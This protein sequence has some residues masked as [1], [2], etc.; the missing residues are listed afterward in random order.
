MN[1]LTPFVTHW[2]AA[3]IGVPHRPR[4]RSLEGA[5]CWG[6]VRLALWQEAGVRTPSFV[7]DYTDKLERA[8]IAAIVSDET[9]KT[10][11]WIE[12]DKKEARPFDVAIFG[13]PAGGLHIGLVA[14]PNRILHVAAGSV[15]E[16]AWLD[17]GPWGRR[18]ALI[19][20]H[21][22]LMR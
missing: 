5:D 4:G 9:S 7:D 21:R 15:S 20:R 6:L 19:Y 13:A 2:S 12:V 1:G 22:D 11:L 8:E 16:L 18:C 3:Y 10:A 17:R 14:L